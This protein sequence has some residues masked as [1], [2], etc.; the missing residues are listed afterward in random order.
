MVALGF[1]PSARY[2]RSGQALLG[3]PRRLSPHEPLGWM[4]EASVSELALLQIKT[5]GQSAPGPVLL[6]I[7]YQ[8]RQALARTIFC[9]A[10]QPKACWNSDMFDITLSM[11]KMGRECGSV[12]TTMRAISGRTLAHQE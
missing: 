1:A 9:P 3:Q 7:F 6:E 8:T 2:A 10:L 4:A 5:M 12:V 11:R